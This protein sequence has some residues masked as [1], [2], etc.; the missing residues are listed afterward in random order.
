M[1][2]AKIDAR[3]S[4]HVVINAQKIVINLLCTHK[5]KHTNANN[6]ALKKNYANIDAW[7]LA[8]LKKIAKKFVI[9]K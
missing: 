9:L 4:Y 1:P 5:I 6:D 8:I 2:Y 3:K 7:N